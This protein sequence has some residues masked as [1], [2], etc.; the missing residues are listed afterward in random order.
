M[1]DERLRRALLLALCVL[2]FLFALHAKTA[3]YNGSAPAKVTPSTASKLW[4]SGQKMEIQPVD[5]ATGGALFFVALLCVFGLY[6][7]RER[8]V[9]SAFLI[10]PPRD[11]SLRYIH[12][13]LRPPPV[14]A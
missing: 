14:L 9:Q 4:V 13:F 11:F 2:V 12:R 10:P 1:Y 3:V 8:R 7:H 5:S 6:L